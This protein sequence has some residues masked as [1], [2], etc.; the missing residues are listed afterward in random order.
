MRPVAVIGTGMTRFGAFPDRDLRV[1]ALESGHKAL[2]D[3]GIDPGRVEAFYLGNFAG[4]QVSGQS[5][6][7]PYIAAEMGI[8]GTPAT[9]IEAACASGGSAFFHAACAVSAG[10]YDVVLVTG[11]EKMTG[12]A[13]AKAA[14]ILATAADG[15]GEVK[16]GATF[17]PSSP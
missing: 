12:Q 10:F 5:H 6:L 11:V 8:T 2:G 13:A 7:A 16:A 3:C 9:R 15:Q 17:R 1:L 4:P 14:A